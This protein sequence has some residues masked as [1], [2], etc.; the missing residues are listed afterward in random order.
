MSEIVN[1]VD[2]PFAPEPRPSQ[3]WR[4]V[5]DGTRIAYVGYSNRGYDLWVMEFDPERWLTAMPTV[6]D[7]PEVDDNKPPLHPGQTRPATL[8]SRRYQAWRTS[9]PRSVFPTAVDVAT[10]QLGTALGLSTAVTDILG[11]H[12]ASAGL[13]YL[14]RQEVF[15]WQA[16][17][18]FRRLLPNVRLNAGRT[19]SERRGFGRY[20]YERPDGD[21]LYLRTGYGELNTFVS[22]D[23]SLPV[24]RRAKHIADASFSYRWTRLT[25]LDEADAPIDPGAPTT[26]TPEV[27]DIGQ[28][29]IRLSYSALGDGAGRFTMGAER[30]RSAAVAVGVLDERL[31]GDFGDI[32]VSGSYIEVIPMPWR[33]HQSLELS[34]RGGV[35][36]GGLR[37]RGA[38]CVGNFGAG[39]AVLGGADVVLALLNRIGFGANG[40]ALLRG[41]GSAAASGR[42]FAILTAEYRIPIVDIDRGLGTAPFFFQR[43]G[44]VPFVDWGH[45]WTNAI[46]PRDLLLAS[47]ASLAF[48]FRVGYVES[49]SLLFQYAHGFEDELGLDTFRAVIGSAF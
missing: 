13:S 8:R 6:S 39:P 7:L 35:S 2:P 31:G 24:V 34:A 45:A 36:A 14:F 40:C 9:F 29:G 47:G 44:L 38:Y 1:R 33:G 20:V 32:Q 21:D 5:H 3:R 37:R 42:S 12:S 23:V 4:V 15:T 22:G 26:I 46:A 48:S 16:A 49:V 41:Y 19:Y 17:Y 25:N 11:F 10:S 18:A 43:V 28:A 30:G 27:G